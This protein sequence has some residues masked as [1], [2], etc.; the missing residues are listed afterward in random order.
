M[1]AATAIDQRYRVRMPEPWSNSAWIDVR[2][3]AVKAVL[4]VAAAQCANPTVTNISD[5]MA[6]FAA[7]EVSVRCDALRSK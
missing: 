1:V 5:W 4:T 2:N 7:W 3:D 6:G